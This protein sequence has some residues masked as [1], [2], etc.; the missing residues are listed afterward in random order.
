MDLWVEFI[1]VTLDEW[2]IGDCEGK[3]LQIIEFELGKHVFIEFE[4]I[5]VVAFKLLLFY[6]LKVFVACLR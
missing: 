5:R 1:N 2:V 6:F 3:T 4:G